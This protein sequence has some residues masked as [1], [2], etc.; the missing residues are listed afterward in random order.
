MVCP[1]CSFELIMTELKGVEINY[2]PQC[3][4]V[5][6]DRGELDKIIEK[7]QSQDISPRYRDSREWDDDN[8][9]DSRRRKGGREW[10]DDDDDDDDYRER[11]EGRRR[12]SKSILG[13]LF[14]FG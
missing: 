11:S 1:N 12:K 7:S 5:W 3:R 8:Y 9:D 6:L 10:D 2:C 14:D 13:D 4:C